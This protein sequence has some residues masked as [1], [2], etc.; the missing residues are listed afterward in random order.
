MLAQPGLARQVAFHVA[1]GAVQAPNWSSRREK[2]CA[3]RIR[4]L[5]RGAGVALAPFEFHPGRA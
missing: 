5:L 3:S 1:N 2:P 4:K